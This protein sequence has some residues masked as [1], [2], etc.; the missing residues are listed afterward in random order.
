MFPAFL[1]DVYAIGGGENALGDQRVVALI[2][3]QRDGIGEANCSGALIAPR[4]VMTSAHC[5]SRNPLDGKFP[6]YNTALP[7]SGVLAESDAP[8]WVV[9]PGVKVDLTEQTPRARAIAQFPSPL[10]RDGYCLK[11]NPNQCYGPIHDFGVIVLDR[12]L[13]SKTYRIATVDELRE[14]VATNGEIVGLGY[15]LTSHEEHLGKAKRDGI[16]RKI[17]YKVRSDLLQVDRARFSYYP[18]LMLL[19]TTYKSGQFTCGGD[20]GMPGWF[21]K[22]G[23]WIYIGAAGAGMGPECSY[24]PDDPFWKDPFWSINAGDHYDT[25]QAYPEEFSAALAFLS[26]QIKKERSESQSKIALEK[27]KS[28]ITCVK[29]KLTKKITSIDPKCPKGYKKR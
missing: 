25:A 3:W 7:K 19:Q 20:S 26:E 8:L 6:S 17:S 16:P 23:E 10:Y 14:L 22:N 11:E 9:A 1:A 21:E 18:E 2:H 29:G 28:T 24:A 13:S 5:L 27:K 12:D 15:G 4:I